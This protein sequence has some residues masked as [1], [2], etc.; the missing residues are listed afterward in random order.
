MGE[1]AREKALR[2]IQVGD[3]FDVAGN[4]GA[5]ITCLA[6]AIDETAIY[7]RSITHQIDFKFD[8][9]TGVGTGVDDPLGGHIRS[10]APLPHDIYQALIGLDR[11]YRG[12]GSHKLSENEKRALV[13]I[14]HYYE[15]HPI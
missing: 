11:R 7:A 3:L 13:F 2:G 4:H 5:P 6:T 14:Y 8:R 12:G 9:K 10:V 15:Q 1:L